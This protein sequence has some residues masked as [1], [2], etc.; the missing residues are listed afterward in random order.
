MKT[1]HYRWL[2][3]PTGTTGTKTIELGWSQNFYEMLDH[4]NRLG[5]GVWQYSEIHIDSR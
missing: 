1:Y 5:F 3:I 4:W 2:H